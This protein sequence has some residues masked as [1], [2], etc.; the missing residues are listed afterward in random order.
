MLRTLIGL[1]VFCVL[2]GGLS[3]L[4]FVGTASS[5]LDPQDLRI[6]QAVP[7]QPIHQSMSVGQAYRAIPHEQV[8]FRANTSSLAAPEAAYLGTLFSL[9][10]LAVVERVQLLLRVREKAVERMHF[11]NYDQILKR[12]ADLS[13]PAGL[14]PLH[15]H[16]MVSIMEEKEFFQEQVAQSFLANLHR[17]HP[18]VQKSHR[19]L[20]AAYQFLMARY[21]QEFSRNQVA[22]FQ[23]LC[24]L[25]FI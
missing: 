23:H 11:D 13:I 18:L 25:D 10:D 1:V 7:R 24:A 12:L 9:V 14:E 20:V 8:T 19:R 15:H 22:F 17:W 6:L 21:P 3:F 5:A 4:G 2:L 16:V